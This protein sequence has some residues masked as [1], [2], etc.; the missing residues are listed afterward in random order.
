MT[1]VWEAFS[2]RSTRR[3]DAEAGDLLCNVEAWGGRAV[4]TPP[5]P[6][7]HAWGGGLFPPSPPPRTHLVA[8]PHTVRAVCERLGQQVEVA[9]VVAA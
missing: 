3:V 2:E 5:L 9:E 7:S 6:P 1:Q 4:S 8:W